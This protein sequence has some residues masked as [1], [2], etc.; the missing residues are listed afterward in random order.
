M[1]AMT[2]SSKFGELEK[3]L[4]QSLA[5]H[6]YDAGYM[7]L[8]EARSAM[9]NGTYLTVSAI[10]S[11]AEKASDGGYLSVDQMKGLVDMGKDE[12]TYMNADTL[13]CIAQDATDAGY[14]SVDD[15]QK[16]VDMPDTYMTV[17]RGDDEDTYLTLGSQNEGIYLLTEA[18]K[19][20]PIEEVFSKP[21]VAAMKSRPLPQRPPIKTNS[22]TTTKEADKSKNKTALATN[23]EEK[24][25][26]RMTMSERMKLEKKKRKEENALKKARHKQEAKE[27]KERIKQE[28]K[29]IK[30]EE[31]RRKQEEK[32]KLLESRRRM[33]MEK[34]ALKE[35]ARAAAKASK[36]T[37]KN[38]DKKGN[39]EN[40]KSSS[41]AKMDP[42][43]FGMRLRR[44][45]TEALQRDTQETR[46][47]WMSHPPSTRYQAI[48]DF[49]ATR[50]G[51]VSCEKGDLIT[52]LQQDESGFY[53]AI[54]CKNGRK[55]LVPG[56]FLK[57]VTKFD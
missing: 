17:V 32:N 24:P 23:E 54:N 30:D 21:V 52:V 36:S 9:D 10:R 25:E 18:Q 29:R 31:K 35:K 4:M 7:S 42:D 5:H 43:K 41:D 28:K 53:V 1:S 38:G 50:E 15:M 57:V 51:F 46:L 45:A 37:K 56:R 40:I 13:T 3:T 16:L 22:T 44:S 12:G 55:G 19:K 8:E 14:L 48:K 6:A 49:S 26:R 11:L 20:E 33:T 34:K 47:R 27:E 2:S 39:N